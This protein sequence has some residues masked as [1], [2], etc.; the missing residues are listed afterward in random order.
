MYSLKKICAD[1]GV[2]SESCSR[3]RKKA[4]RGDGVPRR[5][6]QMIIA[7]PSL[8]SDSPPMIIVSEGGAPSWL[9][10]ETT[11]TGSVADMTAPK[12]R[13]SSQSQLNG[14]TS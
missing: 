9:R 1:P 8:S 13:Q 11:A 10:S 3:T 4:G 7:E 14:S 6:V 2:E 5:T 12:A